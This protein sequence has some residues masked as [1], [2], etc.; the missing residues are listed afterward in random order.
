MSSGRKIIFTY[1][2][3]VYLYFFKEAG[4]RLA[5]VLPLELSKVAVKHPNLV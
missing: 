2:E 4:Q 3:D 1:I 5:E